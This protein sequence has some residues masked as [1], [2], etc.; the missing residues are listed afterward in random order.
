MT[1]LFFELTR[2]PEIYKKLHGTYRVARTQNN[3]KVMGGVV[4]IMAKMCADALLRDKLFEKG[5]WH[6]CWW[7]YAL[8]LVDGRLCN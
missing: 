2:N 4:G 3:E 8:G 7:V 6:L 1:C 5:L